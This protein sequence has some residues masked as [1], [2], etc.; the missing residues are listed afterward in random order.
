MKQYLKGGHFA[1]IVEV[2]QESMAALDSISIEDFR[3]CFRQ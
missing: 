1:D 2:Q 3:Q